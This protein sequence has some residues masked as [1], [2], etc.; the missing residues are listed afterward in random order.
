MS[1]P[2]LKDS[3]AAKIARMKAAAA[4]ARE[5]QAAAP[6]AII[7]QPAN[8]GIAVILDKYG[9]QITLN[10]KQ[11][12]FVSLATSGKS[13][14]LIGAAGTGK[15]TSQYAVC[16]SLILSGKAGLLHS[17]GHSYLPAAEVPGIVIVAFTRR[18]VNNIRK[19]LPPD[20]QQ[21]CL[22]IH[23]LLE[24][25]PEK[26]EVTDPVTGKSRMSM[27]FV[28]T[29]NSSNPLPSSIRTL[30]FEESSMVGTDLYTQVRAALAHKV[31]EIFLG[32][33]QQLPPVFGPAILG[34]KLLSLPTIELTEVY[35]QALESPIISLAHRILSGVPLPAEDFPSITRKGELSIIPWTKRI[36]HELALGTISQFFQRAYKNGGWNPDE[37]AILTPYNKAF[38]TLEL[39]R[40]LAN[41]LARSRNATTYEIIAGYNKLYFSPGD[42]VLYEKEDA[43]I[44]SIEPNPQYSGVQPQEESTELDYWGHYQSS[45]DTAQT[46]NA[47]GAEEPYDIDFILAN[48]AKAAAESEDRVHQA[49]HIITVQ[50][51]SIESPVRVSSAAEI[52]NLLHAYALT[53]HKS[54]GSEYKKVFLLFHHTQNAMISRELLYTA[55][56]RAREELYV[57]CEADTFVK[58]I[59][60]QRIKGNTL[61]EKAEQFKGKNWE[62]MNAEMFS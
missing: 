28:P 33:I 34:F 46:Q 10:A 4:A 14:I 29:R 1:T 50:L 11:Q 48:A 9:K 53:V 52:N 20:L 15:T 39:N 26:Y 7:P 31:Q 2:N 59:N 5:L 32:D 30:I 13:C 61:A 55:V 36:E 57:I 8:D 21:N 49:S 54:Q 35:R 24:Y 25:A 16:Q 62:G 18:A 44:L 51:P 37:D 42:K 6:P 45:G 41:F 23:K 12:E 19:S 58:G 47:G 27:R 56:T 43:I 60:S 38:G 22:T 17:D 3:L 40:A